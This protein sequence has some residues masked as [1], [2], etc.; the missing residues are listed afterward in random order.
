MEDGL[1][2]LAAV[3]LTQR[4]LVKVKARCVAPPPLSRPTASPLRLKPGC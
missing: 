3:A 4:A 2:R 1:C